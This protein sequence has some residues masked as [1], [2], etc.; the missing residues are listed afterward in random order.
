[1]SESYKVQACRSRCVAAEVGVTVTPP[2][3]AIP[4]VNTI[5]E[6]YSSPGRSTVDG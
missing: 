1:M 6:R 2:G 3:Y 4:K 5:R